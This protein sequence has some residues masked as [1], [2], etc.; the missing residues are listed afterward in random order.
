MDL[1]GLIRKILLQEAK[2][3][4]V[5]AK[6]S[7]SYTIDIRYVPHAVDRRVRDDIKNYSDRPID[8]I[9]IVTFMQS[10]NEILA[11]HIMSGEIKHK[12]DFV[13]KSLKWEL[14]FSIVPLEEGGLSWKFIVT[15][16]FR[17]SASNPFRTGFNQLVI[18]V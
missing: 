8:K 14:A 15:T 18:N 11:N 5:Y 2:K 4:I 10:I 7:L 13:V 12:Q 1:K 16:V 6:P 9:E 17:E 3:V